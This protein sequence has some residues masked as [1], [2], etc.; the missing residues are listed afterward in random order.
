MTRTFKAGETVGKLTIVREMDP[1]MYRD[2]WLCRC[3]CGNGKII[4]GHGLRAKGVRSCGC[5]RSSTQFKPNLTLT[6]DGVR[7][8]YRQWQDE[9][10]THRSTILA[11]VKAGWSAFDAV[12]GRGE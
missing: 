12:Y 2:R 3:R 6:I 10:G 7:R 4:D 1:Y 5:S 9:S 11:R 8:T